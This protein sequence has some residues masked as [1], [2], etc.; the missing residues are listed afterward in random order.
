MVKMAETQRQRFEQQPTQIEQLR[1]EIE[2]R[3]AEQDRRLCENIA[4]VDRV[5]TQAHTN[6]QTATDLASSALEKRLDAMNEFR[7]QLRDQTGTFATKE[8]LDAVRNLSASEGSS[9]SERIV[10][11]ENEMSNWR[12]RGATAMAAIGIFFTLVQV[13]LHFVGK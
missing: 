1:R 8:Q 2:L 10:K 6:T 12:G 13:A 5:T 11:I 9:R 3:M 4:G 7:N